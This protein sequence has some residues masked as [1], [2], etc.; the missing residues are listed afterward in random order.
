MNNIEKNLNNPTLSIENKIQDLEK[1]LSYINEERLIDLC[2]NSVNEEELEWICS[3]LNNNFT[4]LFADKGIDFNAILKSK[5]KNP[6]WK[7]S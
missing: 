6:I 4:S 5:T 7:I 3:V 2:S 1:D